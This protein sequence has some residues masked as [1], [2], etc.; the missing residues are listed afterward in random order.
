M[1]ELSRTRDVSTAVSKKSLGALA[2]AAALLVPV[3]VAAATGPSAHSTAYSVGL[4][5]QAGYANRIL[6]ACGSANHYVFFRPRHRV[7][8]KGT[9]APAPSGVRMVKVKIKKCIRGRFVRFRELH[10]RV[11]GRGAYQGSFSVRSRGFYFA[12]TY[13]YGVRPAARSAKQHFRVL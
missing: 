12:R 3:G 1:A 6:R 8:F 4:N 13:F 10:L 11:N 5:L 9:V 7:N 2:L